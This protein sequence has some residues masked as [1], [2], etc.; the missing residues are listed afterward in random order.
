M[1]PPCSL[2]NC[3]VK[4]ASMSVRWQ[5]GKT[6]LFYEQFQILFAKHQEASPFEKG[7]DYMFRGHKI[8]LRLS[9]II[10]FENTIIWGLHVW[11]RVIIW[12]SL[13]LSLTDWLNHSF[14][15]SLHLH[16]TDRRDERNVRRYLSDGRTEER[17]SPRQRGS[18][19]TGSHLAWGM[20]M[21]SLG[22]TPALA[23]MIWPQLLTRCKTIIIGFFYKLPANRNG[24]A[25]LHYCWHVPPELAWVN[26]SHV[27]E[28]C[29]G[30]DY[31]WQL[32]DKLRPTGLVTH[33]R[34]NCC[35]N[36][37]QLL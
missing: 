28:F 3:F 4:H 37:K 34:L 6:K 5:T 33:S 29:R 31:P 23:H 30:P 16:T 26:H 11:T 10:I 9:L 20:R 21:F 15:P 19:V 24:T 2:Q 12:I 13:N 36:Y 22:V 32:L 7:L 18:C 14:D 35:W 17:L 27:A 25:F 8:C 1:V